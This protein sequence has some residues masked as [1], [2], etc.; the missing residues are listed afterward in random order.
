MCGLILGFKGFGCDAEEGEWVVG[1]YKS[2]NLDLEINSHGILVK[3]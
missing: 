1:E 2:L 3:V